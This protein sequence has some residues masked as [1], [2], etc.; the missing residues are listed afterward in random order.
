MDN[1]KS[2]QITPGL[3]LTQEMRLRKRYLV[4]MLV[5]LASNNMSDEGKKEEANKQVEEFMRMDRGMLRAYWRSLDIPT[6]ESNAD[7]E[8]S[9]GIV[10]MAQRFS[11]KMAT[12]RSPELVRSIG[13][14]ALKLLFEPTSSAFFK[15]D[16]LKKLT[17]WGVSEERRD[18][19]KKSVKA[20]T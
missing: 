20:E 14:H 7:T 12:G 4:A 15:E 16:I 5:A 17:E 2:D 9:K 6:S 19:F 13:V 11:S 10:K 8:V 1:K 3:E 18:V